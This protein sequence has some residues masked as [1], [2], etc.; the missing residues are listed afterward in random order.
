[1]LVEKLWIFGDS[2]SDPRSSLGKAS[3]VDKIAQL[4]SVENFSC[5]GTG[6]DWSLNCF[7]Q[8]LATHQHTDL[9]QVNLIFFI[10][11]PFRFNFSFYTTPEDQV[12]Y[13]HIFQSRSSLKDQHQQYRK[14]QNFMIDF[15]KYSAY[16]V[17]FPSIETNKIIGS[18][19]IH[20]DKF[21]KILA[22]PLFFDAPQSFHSERFSCVG[23]ALCSFE[24]K[25]NLNEETRANHL[26]PENHKVMLE[27]LCNWIDHGT[28]IDTSQFKFLL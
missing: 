13:W 22:W 23:T 8:Q 3:W 16:S 26:S 6:P 17:D 20:Q 5:R 1:M 27:Q 10:S 9:S 12:L 24:K 7:Y 28:V 14:Y 25:A 18:L 21:K 4:Y 15:F 2:Y 11:D 19:C